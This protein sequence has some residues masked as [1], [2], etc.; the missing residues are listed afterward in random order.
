[1][2]LNARAKG[3]GGER[4]LLRLLT[5]WGSEA[6][7]KLDLARNVEQ[8]RSGGHDLVGLETYQLSVEVKRVEAAGINRW[9]QQA[10]RQA[11]SELTPVLAWRRNHQPWR[12]RVRAW[13]HPAEVQLDIDL[14][15][16]PFKSWF[17]ARLNFFSQ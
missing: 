6:G 11:G 12:F 2:P 10:V 5:D 9:W 4:E 15:L 3:Q 16:E 14:E 7:V 17:Q 13:V 1:M 8:S